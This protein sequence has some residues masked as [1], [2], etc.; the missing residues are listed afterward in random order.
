MSGP[1]SKQLSMP[2]AAEPTPFAGLSP[3]DLAGK[4]K[5]RGGRTSTQ[6]VILLLVLTVSA[7][8]LWWMRREG[9]RV[10]VTFT[11]LKVDYSEPDAEKAR[12]YARIMAD[13]SRIQTPLDVALGEFGKSPFML[14]SGR[15]VVTPGPTGLTTPVNPEELAARQAA[16]RAEARRQ[17]LETALGNIRLQSV[18]DGRVPLAR[19][20][21]RTVRVGDT[22]GEFFEVVAIEGRGVMV[23]ADGQEFMLT[24]AERTTDAP[25]KSPVKL[26]PAP[27][28]GV[29]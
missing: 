5:N 2:G 26:G 12:T 14:D 1:E 27:K 28:K 21:D 6:L 20:D 15:A 11:E 8:S 23:K 18:M 13:L 10:G 16:E 4:R 7:V 19:I 29:K 17:E 3:E 22:V 9:T 24:I 25:K